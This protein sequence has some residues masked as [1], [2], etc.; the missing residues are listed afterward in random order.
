[1]LAVLQ[2]DDLVVI[3]DPEFLARLFPFTVALVVMMV[4]MVVDLQTEDVIERNIRP[5]FDG[6]PCLLLLVERVPYLV[7]EYV[8]WLFVVLICHLWFSLCCGTSASKTK[9]AACAATYR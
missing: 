9:I 3:D 5:F 7:D 2:N 4:M 6:S 8:D 1:V